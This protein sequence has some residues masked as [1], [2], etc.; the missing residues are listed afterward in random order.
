MT[1]EE[2]NALLE[3]RIELMRTTLRSKGDEYN[4]GTDRLENFKHQAAIRKCSTAEAVLGNLAKHV[5]SIVDMVLSVRE[6]GCEVWD[7]K[8]GDAINY[9][10]LLEAVVCEGPPAEAARNGVPRDVTLALEACQGVLTG[11]HC[12][13]GDALEKIRSARKVVDG[14]P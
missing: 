1:N 12:D 14:K 5:A 6:F 7:E 10:V 9:L 2:F 13:V 4:F 3:R 8:I 11:Q